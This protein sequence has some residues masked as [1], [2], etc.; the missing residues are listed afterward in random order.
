M[1]VLP[2]R[3]CGGSILDKYAVQLLSR[4]VRDLDEIYGYIA[5][6]LQEPGTAANLIGALEEG[7]LSLEQMPFRCPERRTGSFAHQ[8]YR[9]LFIK[10]YV[11]VFRVDEGKKQVVIVTVQYAKRQF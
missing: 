10:N 9:Q 5:R 11:I 1:P 2:W 7:I 6:T 8:G 4:A 3:V